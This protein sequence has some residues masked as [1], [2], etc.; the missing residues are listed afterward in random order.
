MI[1]LFVVYLGV[2]WLIWKAWVWAIGGIVRE[3]KKF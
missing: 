2:V 3:L 1:I